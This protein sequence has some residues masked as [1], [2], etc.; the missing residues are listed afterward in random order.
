MT[1]KRAN[2]EGTLYRRTSDGLWVGS[3][4]LPTGKRKPVYSKTQAGARKKLKDLQAKID[5]GLPITTGKGL[6][7]EQYL[8]G[9]WL[10]RTLPQR[11][12]A[13]RLAERTLLS[14]SSNVRL[15]ITPHLGYVELTA[16]TPS[17]LRDWLLELQDKP[18]G[19]QK[20]ATLDDPTPEP[21]VLSSRMVAYCHAILRTALSDAMRD[22]LVPRN[23]ASLVEPPTGGGRGRALSPEET[24]Q[25]FDTAAGDRWADVWMVLLGL[26]LR[27]GEALALEWSRI[28]LEQGLADVGQSL[29]RIRGE[30]RIVRGK[31]ARSH[32][33]IQIPPLVLQVLRD[34]R[35]RQ[36]SE[37]ATAEYWANPELVFTTRYGTPIEPRNLNR[38]WESLCRKAGVENA[39]PH[40]LRHTAATWLFEEGMDLK[41][42]QHALRHSRLATTSEVYTHLTVTTQARTTAAMDGALRRVHRP[43]RSAATNDEQ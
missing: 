42:I 6:T 27:R 25:L 14:Y 43:E 30:L 9:E 34:R 4:T 23:V 11:V 3:V 37:I 35:E 39:R 32:A 31:T 12:A 33:V 38:A 15:H 36:A 19:R 2:G 16:L 22:E 26:A 13:G 1:R 18:S 5:A 40:D 28:D 10:A 17:H 29:Q 41:D 24:R 20:K 7:V 8:V 21:R